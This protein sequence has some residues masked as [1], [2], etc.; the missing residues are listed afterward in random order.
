MNSLGCMTCPD[1]EKRLAMQRGLCHACYRLR[2]LDV[3]AGRATWAELAAKGMCRQT[4]EEQGRPRNE[5]FAIAY[6]KR[7]GKDARNGH[8]SAGGQVQGLPAKDP[9]ECEVVPGVPPD[10]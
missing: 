10:G 3:L 6:S 4:D 2:R 8:D 1:G 5:R 7:R 9:G